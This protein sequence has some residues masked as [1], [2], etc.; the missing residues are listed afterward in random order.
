MKINRTFFLVIL[1]TILSKSLKTKSMINVTPTSAEE[2][3]SND[4][5]LTI[6]TLPPDASTKRPYPMFTAIISTCPE[7]YHSPIKCKNGGV[8]KCKYW[9]NKIVGIPYCKCTEEYAGQFCDFPIALAFLKMTSSSPFIKYKIFFDYVLPCIIIC[10]SL[11]IIFYLILSKRKKCSI[12][13]KQ[14]SF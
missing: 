1:F 8:A 6:I 3:N 4:I 11:S 12:K 2:K 9:K 5:N 14:L 7:N 13:K 10:I